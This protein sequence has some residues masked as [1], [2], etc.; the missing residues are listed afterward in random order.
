M[1]KHT[2]DFRYQRTRRRSKLA[3]SAELGAGAAGCYGQTDMRDR[4][5]PLER[6][7]D[8]LGRRRDG[9]PVLPRV[10]NALVRVPLV[11]RGSTIP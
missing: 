8:V 11:L 7:V 4:I 2:T 9:Y 6:A 3:A 1:V 10:L 5:A